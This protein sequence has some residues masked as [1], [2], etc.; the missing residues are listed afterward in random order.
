MQQYFVW[1]GLPDERSQVGPVTQHEY[2]SHQERHWQVDGMVCPLR[3]ACFHN[4]RATEDS[5]ES[6]QI[7]A[8]AVI[9]W[10]DLAACK[11][12]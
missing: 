3:W 4:S 2:S 6:K 12:I 9:F 11:Q 8:Q 1:M 10:S 5:F 7:G